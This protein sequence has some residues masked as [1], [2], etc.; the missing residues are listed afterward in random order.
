MFKC[1]LKDT[2]KFKNA[3]PVSE[4]Q[5][6]SGLE[7]ISKQTKWTNTDVRNVN[8]SARIKRNVT[9]HM[10]TKHWGSEMQGVL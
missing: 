5:S 2:F 4:K 6:L 7:N 1:P 9:K 3:T 10:K 8:T